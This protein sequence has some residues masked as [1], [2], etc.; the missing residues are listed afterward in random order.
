MGAGKAQ[1]AFPSPLSIL[2]GK[3]GHEPN[4]IRGS[5]CHEKFKDAQSIMTWWDCTIQGLESR[6]ARCGAVVWR[7]CAAAFLGCLLSFL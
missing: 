6:K 2:A 1:I 7:P 5:R 4:L 3:A